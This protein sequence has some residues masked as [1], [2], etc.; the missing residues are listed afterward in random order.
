[1]CAAWPPE[2]F[3]KTCL[4]RRDQPIAGKAHRKLFERMQPMMACCGT[5]IVLFKG[6]SEFRFLECSAVADVTSRY[7][8]DFGVL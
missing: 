6:Q 7:G 4:N 2:H 3:L 5:M 1:M 8:V